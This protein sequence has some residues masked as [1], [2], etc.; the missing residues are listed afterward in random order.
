MPF[1]EEINNIISESKEVSL[2][3]LPKSIMLSFSH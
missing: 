3:T 1:Y 2:E